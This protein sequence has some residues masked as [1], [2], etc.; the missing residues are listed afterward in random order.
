MCVTFLN[1][2]GWFLSPQL[3]TM[4][5]EMGQILQEVKTMTYLISYDIRT[6]GRDYVPLLNAI[7]SFGK[8]RRVLRSCW[9]LES[10]LSATAIHNTLTACIDHNDRLLV[11]QITNHT[12]TNL[13]TVN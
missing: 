11:C 13:I 2:V 8:A 10:G 7:S 1:T 4:A 6:P 3:Y 5:L 12:A 9:L